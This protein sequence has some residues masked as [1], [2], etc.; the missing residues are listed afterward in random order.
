ML[1]ADDLAVMA[2]SLEECVTNLKAW[3]RGMESKGLKVNMRKT[4]LVVSGPGLDILRDSGA[5]QC[6]VCRSGVRENSIKC[7][8]CNLWVHKKCSDVRGR[9]EVNPTSAQDAVARLDP[10]M[11]D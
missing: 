2:D 9:R 8:K 11:A 4:K 1:Y 7:S 3:K 6:A 10:L 5:F